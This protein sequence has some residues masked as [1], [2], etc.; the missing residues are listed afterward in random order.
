LRNLFDATQVELIALDPD[1]NAEGDERFH[2]YAVLGRAL[3]KDA[4]LVAELLALGVERS[5]GTRARCFM[6]RHGFRFIAEGATH[7]LLL[8]LECFALQRIDGDQIEDWSFDVSDAEQLNLHFTE[9]G[10]EIHP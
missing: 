4:A 5:D 10:L 8:C 1:A 6:P 7:E 2:G 3:T 9:A